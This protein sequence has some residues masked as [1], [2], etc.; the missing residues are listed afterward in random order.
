MDIYGEAENIAADANRRLADA[1]DQ[2]RIRYMS[3]EPDSVAGEGW[4]VLTFWELP[5]PDGEIWPA[6]ELRRYRDL[7]RMSFEGVARTMCVFRDPEEIRD[8]EL[9]TGWRVRELA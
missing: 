7:L 8:E 4:L 2:A 5:Y 9:R 3:V 1:G 6:A